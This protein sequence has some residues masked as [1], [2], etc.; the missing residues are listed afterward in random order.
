LK[1]GIKEAG[2]GK[3]ATFGKTRIGRHEGFPKKNRVGGRRGGIKDS[4]MAGHG[5]KIMKRIK[6]GTEKKNGKGGP[7][8][9]LGVQRTR[10]SE[11]KRETGMRHGG[12]IVQKFEINN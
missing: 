8:K 3:G 2:A 11:K 10:T 6:P 5:A 4:Y 12:R 9:E 1:K 7:P